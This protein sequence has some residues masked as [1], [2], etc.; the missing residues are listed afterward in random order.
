MVL[1]YSCT[2]LLWYDGSVS[3][4]VCVTKL[5]KG[6]AGLLAFFLSFFFLNKHIFKGE[7][8]LVDFV[9]K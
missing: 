2:D 3:L 4:C 7:W 1:V 8:L 5:N 6:K 9:L